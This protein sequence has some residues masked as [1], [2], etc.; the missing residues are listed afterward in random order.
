[1]LVPVGAI[2]GLR[3]ADVKLA[4]RSAALIVKEERSIIPIVYVIACACSVYCLWKLF[5]T[6]AYFPN[7]YFDR[8]LFCDARLVRRTELFTELRYLYYAFAYAVIPIGAT[9]ALL[10]W[11]STGRRLHVIMFAVLFAAVLYLNLVL[12]MKANLVI[13]FVTLLLA[14]IVARTPFRVH[15]WLGLAAVG[16]LLAMQALIGCYWNRF[17]EPSRSGPPVFAQLSFPQTHDGLAGSAPMPAIILVADSQPTRPPMSTRELVV[18]EAVRFGRSVIFR[19]A[20]SMPYYVQVFSNP[21]ERCGIESNS[22][23]LLPRETCYPATKIGTHANPGNIQAF[24]SAPA[25]VNAYGELGIGYACI[26]LLLGGAIM[27]LSWG[28]AQKAQSPLFQAAGT[29]VCVFAYYLSQVSFVGALTH[30]NGFVWYLFPIAAAVII[31]AFA[32]I[33]M[34]QLSPQRNARIE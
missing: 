20:A 34:S 28:L 4:D 7:L 11:T 19:M 14:C 22:L 21:D 12:Y 27:G 15:I 1:L 9:V 16:S 10:S 8:T 25:H 13:F 5:S 29:A 18:D 31:H 32:R 24:Q 23:P 30:S 3:A 26:V 6:G 17:S 2:V 33:V